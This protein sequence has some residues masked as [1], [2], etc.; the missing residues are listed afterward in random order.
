MSAHVTIKN[1]ICTTLQ[2]WG[3]DVKNEYDISRTSKLHVTKF[4]EIWSLFTTSTAVF[5]YI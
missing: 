3:V 4:G 2:I 5:V 1:K